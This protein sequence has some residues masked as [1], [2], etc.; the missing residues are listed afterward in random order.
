MHMYMCTYVYI[1]RHISYTPIDLYEINFPKVM[2]LKLRIWKNVSGFAGRCNDIIYSPP[3]LSK[4]QDILVY[5]GGDVQDIQ[6]NME[7]HADS[8]KYIEWSLENTAKILTVNF[9][10]K[11]IFVVRPKR[12]HQT[13]CAMFSCFDNFVPSSEYGIPSITLNHNAL[14][15]LQELLKSSL[16]LVK[17]SNIDEDPQFSIEKAKLSLVGFSKG[18]VVLNQLLYEIYYYQKEYETETNTEINNTEFNSTEFNNFVKLIKS[19]W[20]LD[21]GHGG[22]KDAW[23]TDIWILRYFSNLRIDVN[24]H[25]TPYQVQDPYRQWIRQEERQFCALLMSMNV[26]VKRTLHFADKPRSLENH[27]KILTVVGDHTAEYRATDPT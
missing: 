27:F 12:M 23:I 11:H 20:W 6:E 14:K 21:G 7:Q 1:T 25:V 10:N 26:P 13:S 17:A 22:L 19:M 5:W 16:E 8:K 3:K 4:C 24:V 2:S 15:H 9:P 18:C